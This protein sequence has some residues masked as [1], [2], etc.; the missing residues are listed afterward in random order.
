MSSPSTLPKKLSPEFL[1]CSAAC[2]TTSLPLMSS[3]PMLSSPTVGRSMPSTAVTSALP[4]TAN[5]TSCCGVQLTLAP[6]SSAV[7]T[8]LR[9][10]SCEAMAGRSMPGSVLSTKR[11]IAISAPVLPAD[12]QACATPSLTRL[13]ATRIDESFFPRSAL[14]GASCISTTS[15]AACTLARWSAGDRVAES[16]PRTSFSRPTRMTRAPGWS[17]RKRSDAATVTRGP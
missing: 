2:F 1:S 3:S 13:T 12:M 6:R 5:W 8:P 15:L 9:V 14:A 7:V 16:S 4:M 10:G 17:S 11:E